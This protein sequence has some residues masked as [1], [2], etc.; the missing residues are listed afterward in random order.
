VELS[1]SLYRRPMTPY[2]HGVLGLPV[3]QLAASPIGQRQKRELVVPVE[4]IFRLDAV[5]ALFG[6]WLS[7]M[8]ADAV[9]VECFGRAEVRSALDTMCRAMVHTYL[10][11][12]LI[13]ILTASVTPLGSFSVGG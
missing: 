11:E 12:L 10:P 8:A 3:A 7:R 4:H 13:P 9:S 1:G 6:A 5:S 2:G